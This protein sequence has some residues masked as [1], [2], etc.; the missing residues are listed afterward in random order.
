MALKNKIKPEKTSHCTY[1]VRWVNDR[2]KRMCRTFKTKILA[3]N[4]CK[5]L[6]KGELPEEVSPEG[7]Q[8]RRVK[9]F[10][11]L[12]KK[13]MDNHVKI[14]CSHSTNRNYEMYLRIHILPFFETIGL[15][16]LHLT[17]LDDFAASLNKKKRQRGERDRT[18]LFISRN[19]KGKEKNLSEKMQRELISL[20]LSVTSYGCLRDYLDRDPFKTYKLKKISKKKIGYFDGK[21]VEKF[22]SWC[23]QGGPYTVP[24]KVDV[25]GKP[26]TLFTPNIERDTE[27]FKFALN[28]GAR[29]GEILGLKRKAIDFSNRRV[30]FSEIYDLSA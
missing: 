3:S 26:L 25:N 12:A 13:Y 20:V 16:D 5:K 28:T 4:F 24:D 22:L 9:T 8:R 7:Q 19:N 29:E 27:I 2:N 15:E 18:S 21:E 1:R 17:D 23:E 14:N 10:G 6:N 11:D 30:W